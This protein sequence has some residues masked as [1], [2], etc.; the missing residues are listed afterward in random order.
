MCMS[1]Q[2]LKG[3]VTLVL[4][5]LRATVG[6]LDRS[7]RVTCLGRAGILGHDR[8]T[9]VSTS[10]HMNAFANVLPVDTMYTCMYRTYAMHTPC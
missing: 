3:R 10:E 5:A 8:H 6:T 9:N 4:L 2:Q 1:T 7:G